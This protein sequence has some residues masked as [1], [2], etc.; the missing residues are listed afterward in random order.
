M[1]R[2][3]GALPVA[4]QW[5]ARSKATPFQQ[6][7]RDARQAVG[8][9]GP[10]DVAPDCLLVPPSAEAQPRAGRPRQLDVEIGAAVEGEDA[11]AGQ[12]LRRTTREALERLN[13]VLAH[14]AIDPALFL[15][16]TLHETAKEQLEAPDGDGGDDIG[17]RL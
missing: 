2:P 8:A 14:S 9:D 5:G 3:G 7:L 1:P 16:D 12:A 4:A 10:A 17:N 13:N 11:E 15:D 6:A